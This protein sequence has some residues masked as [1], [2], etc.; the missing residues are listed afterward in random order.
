MHPAFH[1][2]VSGIPL[3]QGDIQHGIRHHLLLSM[4]PL[5]VYQQYLYPYTGEALDYKTPLLRA[6]QAVDQEATQVVHYF[7]K[8]VKK[9]IAT[10]GWEQEYF[11]VDKSLAG[12]RPDLV[13]AGRTLLGHSSAKG[14]AA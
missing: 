14:T 8:T 12:S 4:A 11:L 10:L 13:L 2:V 9:V 1:Q 3:K 7:D 6:L 5:Y